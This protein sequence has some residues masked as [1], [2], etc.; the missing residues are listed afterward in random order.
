[1]NWGAS[2]EDWFTFV[3]QLNLG[4]DLLP[5]VSNPEAK[6][7]PVTALKTL[8]KTPSVFDRSGRVTGVAQWTQHY[9]TTA[10]LERW[11]AEPDYGL[12]LIG[13][14]V[15][16][17]DCDLTDYA[18]ATRVNAFIDNFL[19][20]QLPVRFRRG[21]PKFLLAVRV[22]QHINKRVIH[23]EHGIIEILGA[24][25]QFIVAGAHIE[26]DGVSR[27]RYEWRDL[28]S[29]IPTI[30]LARL[31]ELIDALQNQY[32]VATTNDRQLAIADRALTPVAQALYDK[33][34][35]LSVASDG[36]TLNVECPFSELHT[37]ESSETTTQY[38]PAHTGGYD[39]EAIICKHGHCENRSIE[40]YE[41]A[42]GIDPSNDFEAIPDDELTE[43][44]SHESSTGF[45]IQSA[46]SFAD[47]DIELE[48]F[49][50]GLLPRATIGLLYGGAGE[51]KTFITYDMVASIASGLDQWCGRKIK[52]GCVLYVCAEGQVGFRRRIRSWA[53]DRGVPLDNIQLHVLPAAPDLMHKGQVRALIAEIARYP[54]SFDLIVIDTYAACMSGDEN[55][56]KD[57]AAVVASCKALNRHAGAMILLV[58][59]SGKNTTTA[60]GSSALRGAVDFEA[61]VSRQKEDRSIRC[62]KLTKLKDG[63]DDSDVEIAFRLQ[64]VELAPGITSCVCSY[65]V[66]VPSTD[67]KSAYPA[68]YEAFI[69][70]Y[71][72]HA[73]VWPD[74]NTVQSSVPGHKPSVFDAAVKSGLIRVEGGYVLCELV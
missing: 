11:M 15:I 45:V 35:V 2:Q 74:V 19:G 8:G 73:G 1:M 7:S 22:G 69:A 31:Q 55:A 18:F 16:G 72:L 39:R 34:L 28:D 46:A 10:E 44:V 60:R 29:G 64:Q 62:L 50:D 42:L 71:Y 53:Q 59:H 63:G 13:R 68:E 56:A 25:Q 38:R 61:F 65:D 33:G 36:L 32:G 67:K 70:N 41:R 58:H 5:V 30:T 54:V 37:T 21:S 24:K 66:A 51:G 17:I 57:A 48:F 49:I 20:L 23:T 3:Y 40:L 26:R 9:A 47:S 14:N 6:L 43:E 52:S 4:E 12:C 27:S